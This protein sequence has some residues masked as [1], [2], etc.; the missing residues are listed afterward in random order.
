M[1]TWQVGVVANAADPGPAVSDFVFKV[2][3]GIQRSP[4]QVM[5]VN[6]RNE[7]LKHGMTRQRVCAR[8]SWKGPAAKRMRF[9][10]IDVV[11]I[12]AGKPTTAAFGPPHGRASPM[13]LATS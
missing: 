12:I 1:T 3:P 13:L 9:N 2:G 10:L 6:S 4:R 8:S 11:Q 7:V 5:L